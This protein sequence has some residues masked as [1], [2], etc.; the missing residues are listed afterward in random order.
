MAVLLNKS[1]NCGFMLIAMESEAREVAETSQFQ[2]NHISHC[3]LKC[4]KDILRY[5]CKTI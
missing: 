3:F 2:S 1:A 4:A 5:R